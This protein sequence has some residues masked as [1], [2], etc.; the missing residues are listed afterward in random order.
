[1]CPTVASALLL[2]AAATVVPQEPEAQAAADASEASFAISRGGLVIERGPQQ[3]PLVVPRDEELGFGVVIGLGVL[4]DAHVGRLTLESGVEPFVA[5]LPVPGDDVPAVGEAAWVRGTAIGEYLGYRVKHEI[6]ARV[7]PQ[8]WP[9]VIYRETQVGSENRRRELK[10]GRVDGVPTL[11][12]RR[13]THCNGCDR[14][15]HFVEGGLFSSEHHCKRCK[16]AEHCIWKP[17]VTR[18][19][20][21]ESIDM[22]SAV[23]LARTMVREDLDEIRFPLLEKD[24][25]WDVTLNSDAQRWIKVP[26]GEFLCRSIKLTPTPRDDEGKGKDSF[27]GLFGIHGTLSIWIQEPTGVPVSIEGIVPLGPF[28]LDIALRLRSFRGTPPAFRTRS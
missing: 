5:S 26:A 23:L 19:I 16:R 14:R 9:H 18:E 1:M 6:E 22:L 12:Y 4:G 15:E 28:D 7:L 27:R 3:L 25:L 20:P 17:P 10:Y 2:L 13:D 11:W 8:E 21:P 24:N